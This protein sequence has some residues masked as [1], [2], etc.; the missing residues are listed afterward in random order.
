MPKG[1][2]HVTRDVRCQ[3]YTLKSIGMSLQNIAK[4]VDKNVSTI[5][6]EITR[7][8]GKRGYRFNQADNTA[9]ERRTKA[10]K[11]AKKLTD[12]LTYNKD[13]GQAR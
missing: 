12:E 7:N 3:I 2:N 1:Y 13:R 4:Q 8:T 9:C 5:S 10:S 11:V 6:R